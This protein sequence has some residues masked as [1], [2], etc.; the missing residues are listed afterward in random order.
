MSDKSQDACYKPGDEVPQS[1]IY[2][3]PQTG[4]KATCVQGEPFPPTTVD[5]Q[6]WQIDIPTRPED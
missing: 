2:I 4:E 1:G 5:D 3:N 6:C